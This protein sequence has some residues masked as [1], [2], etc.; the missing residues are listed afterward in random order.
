MVR[1]ILCLV[2]CAV[3]ALLPLGTLAEETAFVMAGFDGENSAHDWNTNQFFERMQT[4]TGLTFTFQ[5]YT[6][7]AEWQKAK[8]AMFSGGE[9]PDVLFKAALTTDEL[10]RYTDG[11][12]LIDLK[13]LLAENAPNLWA[14]LQDNPDWLAAITL[15]NGKIGALP[16]I[17]LNALQDA[18]WIN[19]EWLDNLG[20]SM[21]GNWEE[22]TQVLTAFRDR[23]PNGNGKKDE[24]PLAFLGPWELK[25]LSH[26]WGVVVNDYNIYLDEA[27][28]VHFWPL[29]DS[30]VELAR[31]LR[32][33]YSD[34]LL[35]PN[36]FTTVDSL[37]RV[38]DTKADI[39]YG[40]L[41][42][43]TPA[44][45]LPYDS[46]M[47]YRVLEPLEYGGKRVYRDLSGQ[48]TR[49]TFAITSACE[50]PAALLRWVD[51]LYTEEGAVEAMVGLEGD[52]YS[53]DEDGSWDWIGGIESMTVEKLYAISVYDSGEMPW[54]FPDAFYQRYAD[55]DVRRLSDDTLKLN[56]MVVKP[57]PTYTLTQEQNA[58]AAA[59]QEDLGPY[60]DEAL[61]SFVLGE[62]EINDQTI[63][64][65]REGLIQ[66]G[67][68]DM[69]A[70]WQEI[71]QQ[72]Q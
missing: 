21:P 38:T 42:G 70:F 9:L 1:R 28:Q 36:G 25:F 14:L 5:E 11:G 67:A 63:A 24:I 44:N 68:E 26:A 57:F 60:V 10:I 72:L 30:F 29:E 62:T 41:F 69:I 53:V 71:A 49:G 2:C 59:L 19:G 8:D 3:L 7:Y 58:R 13:P 4:R 22:L 46:A 12:Q 37:R 35:D 27:G 43:P 50:D 18:I 23:D 31:A 39:V 15:P 52:A 6:S 16:T 45:L 56:E 51:V 32:Q 66:R 34:G 40:A 64:A 20:L 47:K 17:Q 54:K 65:F 61:A 33:W 48:I 55:E